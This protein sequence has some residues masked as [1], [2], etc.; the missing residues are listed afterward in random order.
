MKQT[1]A[2]LFKPYHP[3][4]P[5]IA[6]RSVR[7]RGQAFISFRDKATAERAKQDV[8][9]FPLYGKPIVSAFVPFCA[10]LLDALAPSA[11]ESLGIMDGRSASYLVVLQ[12]T[13]DYRLC[14][15]TLGRGR[16]ARGGR[17]GAGE[18]EGGAAGA[19][20]YVYFR[21]LMGMVGADR[22]RR[23]GTRTSSA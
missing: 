6:H 19:Q 22:Q 17:G 21:Q 5:I 2:S 12:L 7:M 20:E 8:H 3:L 1:L 9:E 14:A 15:H 10:L 11:D 23:H 16:E 4:Q 13:P 18:V